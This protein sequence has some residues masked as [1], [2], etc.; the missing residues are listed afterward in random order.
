GG[1]L[2]P[3]P[4][5]AQGRR[6]ADPLAQEVQL[7]APRLAVPDDLDLLDPRTVHHERPL[8]ADA[9]GDLAHRDRARDATATQAH[10]RALEDL[11]AL[12][13]ALDHAGRHLDRVAGGELGQVAADLVG[14]DLVEDVHGGSF[15]AGARRAA[16]R[17]LLTWDSAGRPNG[18]E[19]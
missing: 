17:G 6:L 13:A 18:G 16:A 4:P 12:L 9:A 5:L 15:P 1:T 2:G 11:D 10:D 3:G 7:R 19:A 14:D 8:D